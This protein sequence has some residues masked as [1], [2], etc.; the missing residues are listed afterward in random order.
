[1]EF[2]QVPWSAACRNNLEPTEPGGS[3]RRHPPGPTAPRADGHTPRSDRAPGFFGCVKFQDRKVLHWGGG[4]FSETCMY[5][6]IHINIAAY[7]YTYT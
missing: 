4:L 2:P 7:F 5:I 6:Y 3:F 1:M